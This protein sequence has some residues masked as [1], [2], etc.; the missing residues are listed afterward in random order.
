MEHTI[1]VRYRNLHQA[2][3][4]VI[5]E[6]NGKANSICRSVAEMQYSCIHICCFLEDIIEENIIVNE[7][8]L[9]SAILITFFIIVTT[10]NNF[11]QQLVEWH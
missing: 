1:Y 3:T 2:I 8:Y 6:N 5:S 10:T 9:M 11:V 7:R 4:N